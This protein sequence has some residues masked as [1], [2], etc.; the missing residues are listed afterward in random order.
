MTGPLLARGRYAALRAYS[1]TASLLSWRS[2]QQSYIAR[3]YRRTR[4]VTLGRLCW[5][6]CACELSR[7]WA[8]ALCQHAL[9]SADNDCR[10]QGKSL[11]YRQLL[12]V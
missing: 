8:R 3:L 10:L 9:L 12:E 6:D 5:V 4:L 1:F 7:M 2:E 11:G